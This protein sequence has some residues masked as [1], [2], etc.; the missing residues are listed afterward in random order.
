MQKQPLLADSS[1]VKLHHD[2]RHSFTE[3]SSGCQGQDSEWNS[4]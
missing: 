1:V 3:Q 4:R 2:I